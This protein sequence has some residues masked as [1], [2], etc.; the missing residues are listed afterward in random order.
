MSKGICDRSK[1]S[2]CVHDERDG[3]RG[4]S[5]ISRISPG[6][7]QS[8]GSRQAS[9]RGSAT[10]V[11]AA[12]IAGTA[13]LLAAITAAGNVML[14]RAQARTVADV[15]VLASATALANMSNDACSVARAVANDN[16]AVLDTCDVE[17]EE[18]QVCAAVATRVSFVQRVSIC[19]RAGPVP[20][21]A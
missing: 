11:G 19:S 3:M 9:D 20:C 2:T 5:H 21:G 10:V 4:R 12:L 18:V 1:A 15:A 8:P 7:Q 13:L 14:C 17:G 16:D 6:T